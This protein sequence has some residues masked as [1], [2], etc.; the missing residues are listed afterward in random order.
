M[1]DIYNIYIP[2]ETVSDETVKIVEI[3]YTSDSQVE[4]GDTIFSIETSKSVIDIESPEAGAFS[5]KLGLSKTIPVGELAGIISKEKLPP[6]ELN[7]IYDCNKKDLAKKIF[8][9]S[10]QSNKKFSKKAL[11]LIESKNL[12]VS[13]FVHLNF[14]KLK[15]VENFINKTS[16]SKDMMERIGNKFSVN[17]V[18]IIGG[19]GHAKMCIDVIKTMK[20]YKLVGILDH[21]MELENQVLGVPVIGTDDD[22]LELYKKGLRLVVNGV[23]SVAN[24]KVRIQIF[25]DLKKIGFS[26]P[27]IIH[28]MSVVEPSANVKEGAQIM[29]GA[30]VGSDCIIGENCIINSGSIVSHD[31]NIGDHS[32]IAPG[33][34]LGGH[35]EIKS[36]VVIG[37]GA[38]IFLSVKIGEN[39]IINNGKNIFSDI[40]AGQIIS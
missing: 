12:N 11:D 13:D 2:N 4:K 21:N 14:V 23:G 9:A 24:N 15:D 37:M 27:A 1:S 38:T 7:K 30:L 39:A 5:H 16:K 26:I 20:Q 35:V 3:N 18:V 40:N 25:N 6:K 36:N 31:S 28:P 34:V 10:N 8:T 29:M 22:L 17:D 32:H 19:G 33:A